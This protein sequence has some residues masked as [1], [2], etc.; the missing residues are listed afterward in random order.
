[1]GFKRLISSAAKIANRTHKSL[2]RRYC[3]PPKSALSIFTYAHFVSFAKAY[4]TA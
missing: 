4:L 1:M 2:G 3:Y